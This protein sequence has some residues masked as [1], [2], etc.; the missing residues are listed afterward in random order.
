MVLIALPLVDSSVLLKLCNTTL[1]TLDG[2]ALENVTIALLL[3]IFLA[4]GLAAMRDDFET[5]AEEEESACDTK[6]S[7]HYATSMFASACIVLLAVVLVAARGGVSCSYL[8]RPQEQL[9]AV[10]DLLGLVSCRGVAIVAALLS[11]AAANVRSLEPMLKGSSKESGWE[12][13]SAAGVH[14]LAQ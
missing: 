5:I 3:F 10:L 7:G 12:Q 11:L 4:G 9:Q 1:Q 2:V 14:K 6:D 8:P 13:C